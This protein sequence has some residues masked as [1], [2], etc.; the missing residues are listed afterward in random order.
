MNK[1]ITAP[2]LLFP[3]EALE[4]AN[5]TNLKTCWEL[6]NSTDVFAVEVSR[7]ECVCAVSFLSCSSYPTVDI[8]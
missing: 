7:S 5:L 6:T 8:L 4:A 2:V 3:D 1:N